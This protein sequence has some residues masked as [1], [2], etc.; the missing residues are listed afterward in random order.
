MSQR[1]QVGDLVTVKGQ[2]TAWILSTLLAW[3]K[4]VYQIRFVGN[5]ISEEGWFYTTQ[6]KLYQR[7][8]SIQLRK[9]Q[10]RLG[11]D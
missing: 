10:E 7:G 11:V 5:P 2:G 8:V 1:Y 4:R 6:L 9:I 3:G